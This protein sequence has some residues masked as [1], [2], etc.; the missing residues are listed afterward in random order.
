MKTDPK[1]VERRIAH[2]CMRQFIPRYNDLARF[3][4]E[5]VEDLQDAKKVACSPEVGAMVVDTIIMESNRIRPT[6]SRRTWAESQ[7]WD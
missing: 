1:T 6:R 2:E 7:P 4:N 3:M 5:N